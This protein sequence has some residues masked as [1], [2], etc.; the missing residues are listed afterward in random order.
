MKILISSHAFAP[1]IGGIETVGE[2][3]ANEFVGLGHQVR[4]LTHTQ[5]AGVEAFSYPVI[6]QPSIFQ[7]HRSLAW[8]DVFWQNNL[9]LRTLW[10]V[11]WLRRP[12]VITHHGSYCRK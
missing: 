5:R 7:L 3:L 11:L 1:S 6:R 4:I 10:P 8:C 2:L 12:L 9:S